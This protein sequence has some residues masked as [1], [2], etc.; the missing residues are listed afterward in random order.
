MALFFLL[1]MNLRVGIGGIPPLLL[2]ISRDLRLSGAG[3][4]M[5]TSAA[6]VS[7]AACAPAGPRLV[8]RFG[9]DSSISLVLVVLAAG[10]GM[11]IVAFTASTLFASIPAS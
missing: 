2:P 11:R 7:M 1:G 5:L 3:Q 9:I 6:I 8:R 4:G 10:E